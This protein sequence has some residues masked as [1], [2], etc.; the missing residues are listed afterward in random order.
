MPGKREIELACS[1]A[2]GDNVN[3]QPATRFDASTG[4]GGRDAGVCL[5]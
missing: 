1:Q 3:R 4:L 2:L 5:P